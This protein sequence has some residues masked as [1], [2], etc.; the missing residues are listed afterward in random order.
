VGA[1]CENMRKDI[2]FVALGIIFELTVAYVPKTS[3]PNNS[4]TS[5]TGK[6]RAK[7][8]MKMKAAVR[9]T[10]APKVFFRP[11]LSMG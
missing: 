2:A 11:Y 10:Q 4:P 9:I 3:P 7:N 1:I 6:V 8:W 5:R